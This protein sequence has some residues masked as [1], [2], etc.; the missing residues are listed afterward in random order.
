MRLWNQK[1]EL[2]QHLPLANSRERRLE[3]QISVVALPQPLCTGCGEGS[4]GGGGGGVWQGEARRPPPRGEPESRGRLR[5]FPRL[6]PK[7]NAFY[8]FTD[9]KNLGGEGKSITSTR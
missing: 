7:T 8:L 2:L 3:V 1:T 5:H 6:N 9:A 4:D